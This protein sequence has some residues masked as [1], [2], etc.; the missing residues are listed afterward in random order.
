MNKLP[1]YQQEMC[2]A[3][4]SAWTEV[5]MDGVQHLGDSVFGGFLSVVEANEGK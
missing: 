1:N 2:D 4:E 5:C 3:V